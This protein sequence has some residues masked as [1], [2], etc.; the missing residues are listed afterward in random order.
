[1][2]KNEIQQ[3]LE[4]AKMVTIDIS[5]DER[6]P[7]TVD[8]HKQKT[9]EIALIDTD[10]GLIEAADI[11]VSGESIGGHLK[12]STRIKFYS[13]KLIQTQKKVCTRIKPKAIFTYP[14][15]HLQD[16]N[17][18]YQITTIKGIHLHQYQLKT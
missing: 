17:I 15:I 13:G 18:Q 11:C 10:V 9:K 2:K 6:V 12:L 16:N 4:R 8:K 1:M 7:P 3:K 14:G 5:N